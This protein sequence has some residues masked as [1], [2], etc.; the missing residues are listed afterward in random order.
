MSIRVSSLL[1]CQEKL[2]VPPLL[3]SLSREKNT[4]VA[5]KKS[6]HHFDVTADWQIVSR[7]EWNFLKRPTQD[8]DLFLYPPLN[9]SVYS[10]SASRFCPC[11]ANKSAVLKKEVIFEFGGG[12]ITLD[13]TTVYIYFVR[14]IHCRLDQKVTQSTAVRRWE[15]RVGRTDAAVCRKKREKTTC[16]ADRQ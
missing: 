8:P 3:S 11:R 5:A 16:G 2:C 13:F 12:L 4:K 9:K 6:F 15:I 10:R 7:P 14:F 1:D